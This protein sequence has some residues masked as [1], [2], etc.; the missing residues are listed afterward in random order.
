MMPSNLVRFGGEFELDR[1]A[2]E[3]RRAGQPLRLARIPMELLQ[4]LLEQPGELVTREQIAERVWG[5]DVFLDIDNG[6]NAVIRRIRQVLGDDPDEPRFIQTIVGRGYRFI[7][8]VEKAFPS[9]VVLPAAPGHIDTLEETTVLKAVAETS[10][11]LDT[12]VKSR[13]NQ[14]GRAAIMAV[15]LA[16]TS[17]WLLTEKSGPQKPIRVLSNRQITT[18]SGLAMTP[19]FSPDGSQMA[20]ATDRGKGNEIFV[21]QLDS[22]GVELQLTSDGRENLEPAWSPEGESLAYHSMVRGGIWLIRA[23]GGSPRRVTEFGSHPSWSRDGK[24]IAFQSSGAR[25]PSAST[26]GAFPPSTIWIVRPDGTDA[27]QITRPGQ[28]EGGHGAPS[29]SPDSKRIVFTST[30]YTSSEIH[31]VDVETGSTTRA[32]HAGPF[33]ADPIYSADGEHLIYGGIS[34]AKEWA[35]WRVK[36]SPKT[37]APEGTPDVLLYGRIKNL[38]LSKDG[39]KILYTAVSTS[40]SLESIPLDK[41]MRLN[42]NPKILRT[43]VGCRSSVPQLSPDGKRIAFISC[44]AGSAVQVW[45]MRRNGTEAAVLTSDANLTCAPNWF[46]DSKR[47]LYLSS[48]GRPSVL[49]VID[50]ETRESKIIAEL[51]QEVAQMNLS[52]DGTQL[53]LASI[54]DGKLSLWLFDMETH[55]VRR[56]TDAS[57]SIGFPTWS[58]DGKALLAQMRSGNWDQLVMVPVNGGPIRQLTS[59][60]GLHFAGSWSR[61]GQHIIFP[62][63]HNNIWNLFDFDLTENREKPLTNYTMTEQFVRYP[64]ISPFSDQVVYERSTTSGNIWMLE[65]Q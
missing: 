3:L 56:L 16:G 4:L 34:G 33:Y 38:Q 32:V 15:V 28:P 22:S 21:R 11:I 46:P 64:Q 19:T 40:S 6:I 45:T 36:V 30:L 61:H 18:A 31:S 27:R 47:V 63:Q 48:G 37:S 12:A 24:W 23:L 49:R 25:D 65:L 62:G 50:I 14:F 9:T 55:E 7:A 20:Y 5:K 13:P 43:D 35:L 1:R 26:S 57:K 60:D 42:G 29:W 59:D 8:P 17:L 39:K 52:P 41:D 10:S 2:Y 54:N 51:K 44:W 53:A 58:P